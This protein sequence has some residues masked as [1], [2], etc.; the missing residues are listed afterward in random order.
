MNVH[1]CHLFFKDLHLQK[2]LVGFGKTKF[3]N[4]E[5]FLLVW[6]FLTVRKT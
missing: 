5:M 3:E 6:D 4:L 1:V 2:E